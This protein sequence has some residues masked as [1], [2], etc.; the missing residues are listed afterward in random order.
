[1]RNGTP[2]ITTIVGAE[3]IVDLTTIGDTPEK[4]AKKA[5]A[6]YTDKTTW[7]K[8]QQKQFIITTTQFA[9]EKLAPSLF[10]K[11]NSLKQSLK[12]HR[13][14]N[15][16]GALLQHQIMASTKFMSKWIEEKNK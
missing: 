11:I 3:G 8:T 7:L 4:F 16:I 5:V 6:L 10:T 15:F 14:K 9:K 13:S 1:M 12:E 2:T